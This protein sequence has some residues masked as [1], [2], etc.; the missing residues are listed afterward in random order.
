MLETKANCLQQV[1]KQLQTNE[2]DLVFVRQLNVIFTANSQ[3]RGYNPESNTVYVSV[4]PMSELM[5]ESD[6]T[7]LNSAPSCAATILRV[8]RNQERE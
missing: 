1:S 8:V 4:P 3:Q 2:S 7:I 6:E 5:Q